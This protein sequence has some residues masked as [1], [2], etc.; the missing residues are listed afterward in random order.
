MHLEEDEDRNQIRM[1]VWICE[2]C[3]HIENAE[4]YLYIGD[5]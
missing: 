5:E 1:Y 3:G 2:K 4:D